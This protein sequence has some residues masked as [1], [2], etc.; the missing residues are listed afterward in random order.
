MMAE[1]QLLAGVP[2][3][4]AWAWQAGPRPVGP[5][6]G[7]FVRCANGASGAGAGGFDLA[8]NWREWKASGHARAVPWTWFGPPASSNGSAC[9]DVLHQIA[10][11]EPVYIVEI[12][13]DPPPEQ[14]LA[15]VRRMRKLEPGARLGF[16]SYPTRAEAERRGGVPW[17]TCVAAFDFGLPQVYTARQRAALH[18]ADSPVVADMQGKPIHVAVFPDADAGWT[19][20]ALTGIARH[21]GA[22]AWAID[23]ASFD[24]WCGQLAALEAGPGRGAGAPAAGG[25]GRAAPVASRQHAEGPGSSAPAPGDDD[26]PISDADADKIAARVAAKL[27]PDVQAARSVADSV[28]IAD[29]KGFVDAKNDELASRIIAVIQEYSVGGDLPDDRLVAAIKRALREGMGL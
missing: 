27:A 25:A 8:R 29:L 9:A 12:E 15:L 3:R 28:A 24:A 5:L 20:S 22:S 18:G 2:T 17:Q 7:V 26:M 21:L 19:Q 14:V 13:S 10:P 1:A 6:D 4:A 16:S 23:Q 11:G